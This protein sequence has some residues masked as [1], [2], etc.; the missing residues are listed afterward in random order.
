MVEGV[1]LT[2]ADYR[3]YG[4]I[5][6]LTISGELN[7]PRGIVE[8]SLQP[9]IDGITLDCRGLSHC[10]S[11][12]VGW[13]VSILELAMKR[14]IERTVICDNERLISIFSLG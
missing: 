3:K 4:C 9:H 8:R 12:G 1:A 10:T 5:H 7:E 2:P 14:G 11:R 13:L 6:T